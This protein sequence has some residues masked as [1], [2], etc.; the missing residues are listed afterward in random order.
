MNWDVFEHW[1]EEKVFPVIPPNSV[2]VVDRA[3]YHT[4][5]TD[6]SKPASSKFTKI[7][8]AKWLVDYKV[9]FKKLRTADD[10]V[11]LK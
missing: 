9:H 10:F 4:G 2:F 3:T 1:M 11:T 5:L 8:F 7:E 6:E